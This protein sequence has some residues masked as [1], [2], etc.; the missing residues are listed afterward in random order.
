MEYQTILINHFSLPL[1]KNL[2]RHRLIYL[3]LIFTFLPVVVFSQFKRDSTKKVKYVGVPVVF[4]TP[5]T[6]W[7]FGLSGSASFKTT[8]KKDT[9][10]RTSVIQLLSIVSLRGQNVEAVDATIYFP[11]EKYIFLFQGS[12]SFF[13]DNFWGIGQHTK[14]EYDSKYAFEQFFIS[15]H[16]KRKVSKHVFLGAIIDFQS[17]FNV[18]SAYGGIFDTTN[19]FGKSNYH[20]A[21]LGA[22]I[23]YDTRNATFWP[24][25]GLFL[26]SNFIFYNSKVAS[27]YSFNKWVV[28]LR[29]YRQLFKNH[30]M[31]FQVYNF[32]TIGDT[33]LRSM[34]LLGGSNNLRGF[35]QGRYRDNCMYSAIAEYRAYL[36]WRLSACAFFGVGDVYRNVS[37]ININSLKH[38]FGGG[39]RISILQKEKL[40]LRLDYGYS[41]KYNQGFYFTVAECF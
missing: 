5:E 10:T 30:I 41:D 14:D 13:P 40:N 8:E 1:F 25:R 38:S 15:P 11:K 32:A 35:Y 31:A 7:A 20:V 16:I 33:P 26:Q 23:S 36:F 37:D 39:L 22:T 21:G 12:H 29:Y 34:A 3:F 17:V 19:F 6:G 18:K 27:T 2:K 4:Q 28:D 9:L 24:T